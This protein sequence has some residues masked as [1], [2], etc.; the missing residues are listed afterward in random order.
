VD[1]PDQ[2]V[3]G[4]T[5]LR[6]VGAQVGDEIPVTIGHRTM[7]F[8]IVGTAAFPVFGAEGGLGDGANMSL[9]SYDR[10]AG[11][12]P[13]VTNTICIVDGAVL[14]V[15]AGPGG[16]R[17]L[18]RLEAAYGNGAAPPVT[19]TSLVNF[20]QSANLPLV[21]GLAVALFGSA[22]V[23]HF[24]LVSVRRRRRDTGMLKTLGMLGRQVRAVVLWQATCVGVVAVVVGVP[25]GVVAGRVAWDLTASGFGVVSVVVV[26]V[27]EVATV[28][29][30]SLVAVNLLALLPARI[31]SRLRP[32]PLLRALWG[33]HPARPGRK[34]RRAP[35][36]DSGPHDARDT[37]PDS[38]FGDRQAGM[39]SV[40]VGRHR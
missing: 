10:L 2:I 19:P 1:G 29:A 11:C 5:S 31:S 25:L 23:L 18:A 33:T 35:E 14:N 17:T 37:V 40:E 3:F 13:P 4:E 16:A 34:G 9:Q 27:S 21:L 20:G 36:S 26:P 39:A 38:V 12:A 15:K 8:R 24:L 6:Q 28:V 22:T 32:V 7:P 30:G